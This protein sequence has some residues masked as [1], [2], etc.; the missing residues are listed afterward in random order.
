MN[1]V[2]AGNPLKHDRKPWNPLTLPDSS[3]CSAPRIAVVESL[4]EATHFRWIEGLMLLPSISGL[5][6]MALGFLA[7][8]WFCALLLWKLVHLIWQSTLHDLR[9][10]SN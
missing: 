3:T 2:F 8:F 9:R 4:L 10:L 1:D 6:A 5:L 7:W